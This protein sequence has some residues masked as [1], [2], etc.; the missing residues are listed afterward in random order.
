MSGSRI[1]AG[2]KDNA[3]KHC[4]MLWGNWARGN[5][6]SI[7]GLSLAVQPGRTAIDSRWDMTY[8]CHCWSV[9]LTTVNVK[10]QNL[11]WPIRRVYSRLNT[12]KETILSALYCT[13][14]WNRYIICWPRDRYGASYCLTVG[15]TSTHYLRIWLSEP[16]L[17]SE[18]T[19][20][21]RASCDLS[22]C[23]VPW[24]CP[25]YERSFRT[26]K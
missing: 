22:R 20:T 16:H 4:I 17:N 9:T 26:L 24:V 8:A 13:R 15:R 6:V 18:G 10:V 2:E 7:S 11:H 25:S 19:F 23:G 14:I 12:Q 1:P 3:Q 5:V 21:F